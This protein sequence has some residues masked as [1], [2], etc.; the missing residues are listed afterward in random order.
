MYRIL[1]PASNALPNRLK[2]LISYEA[3]LYDALFHTL[4]QLGGDRSDRHEMTWEPDGDVVIVLIQPNDY[5]FERRSY[6]L[7]KVKFLIRS[8]KTGKT[9]YRLRLEQHHD[10]CMAGEG[11]LEFGSFE[12]AM[13]YAEKKG[14]DGYE[15]VIKP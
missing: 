5:P 6:R 1:S 13:L 10:W 15:V 11:E 4:S 7:Q 14:L 2:K 9:Y 12:E 8:K 3:S